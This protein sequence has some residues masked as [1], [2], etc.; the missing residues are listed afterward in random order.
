METPQQLFHLYPN[1]NPNTGE[2][3]T[4]G[5]DE[6]IELVD[7]YGEPKIKNPETNYKIS[8]V[9]ITYNNLIK[10]G[11]TEKNLLQL[12]STK[13]KQQIT[14]L[15]PLPQ[16]FTGNPD[17]DLL[18]LKQLSNIDL[19]H[20]CLTNQYLSKLCYNNQYIRPIIK[21]I[22]YYVEHSIQPSILLKG[23]DMTLYDLKENAHLSLRK[24]CKLFNYDKQIIYAGHGLLIH[25]V[26][27]DEISLK[28]KSG[29]LRKLTHRQQFLLN[30]TINP[31]TKQ[32][33][34]PNS[35]E[36]DKLVERYGYP[37]SYL[38]SFKV[39]IKDFVVLN[40]CQLLYLIAQH[41]PPLD[42]FENI[43]GDHIYFEGLDQDYKKK[44]EYQISLGS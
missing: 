11:Y 12:A 35:E 19:Y 41:L 26:D 33:I 37:H 32:I 20:L 43:Y 9:G 1:K 3:I 5:S 8:V 23:S 42:E 40:T 22:V 4:I 6:Y 10:K 7:R 14:D 13:L 39:D 27:I 17:A 44:D 30:S 16:Q 25:L 29:K 34:Q 28:D 36:Y 31:N 24:F 18:I 38:S 2:L 15:T 21:K